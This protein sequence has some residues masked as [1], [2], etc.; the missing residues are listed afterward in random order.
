MPRRR[1]RSPYR[2]YDSDF[3]SFFDVDNFKYTRRG[4][5][6]RRRNRSYT[7]K[8]YFSGMDVGVNYSDM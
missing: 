5:K 1:V 7:S 8:R 3:R 6:Y 2:S 4:R